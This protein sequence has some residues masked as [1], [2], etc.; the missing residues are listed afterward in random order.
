MT[1]KCQKSSSH[2][3]FEVEHGKLTRDMEEPFVSSP[4]LFSRMMFQYVKLI[5]SQIYKYRASP[6]DAV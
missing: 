1:I 4:S 5:I 6:P 2:F 3:V